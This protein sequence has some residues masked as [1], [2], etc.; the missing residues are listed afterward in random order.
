[1]SENPLKYNIDST[2]HSVGQQNNYLNQ[3]KNR[4][5]TGAPGNP[6]DD[7]EETQYFEEQVSRNIPRNIT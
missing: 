5:R 1:M 2:T 4:F 7:R 3:L 6:L